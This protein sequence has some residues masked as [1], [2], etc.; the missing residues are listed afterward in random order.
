M[1]APLFPGGGGGGGG[2]G[3]SAA[4]PRRND[5]SWLGRQLLGSLPFF[6]SSGTCIDAGPE[7]LRWSSSAGAPRAPPW[8]E[9]CE[10]RLYSGG[11]RK[12][13]VALEVVPN[14]SDHSVYVL[15]S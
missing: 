2:G 1:N 11:R 6:G 10:K 5:G 9:G 14:L 15:P 13:G 4:T 8:M 7:R 3:L 12:L